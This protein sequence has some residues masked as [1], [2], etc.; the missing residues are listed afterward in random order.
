MATNPKMKPCPHCNTADYLAVYKYENGWCYVECDNSKCAGN[1]YR[2][3][4]ET[5]ARQ[6]IKSHN[7]KAAAKAA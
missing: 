6:A 3:P 1:F 4:A 2:G 7:D 5:S